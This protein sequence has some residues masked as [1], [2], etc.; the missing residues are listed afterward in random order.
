MIYSPRL[1]WPNGY[2]KQHR[3]KLTVKLMS[4]TGTLLDSTE[5]KF[6]IRHL[7]NLENDHERSWHYNR[8]GAGGCGPC[9]WNS[10]T[11]PE[12][13]RTDGHRNLTCSQAEAAQYPSP[14]RWLFSV[15]GR[16]VFAR[17]GN[18]V[19][20]DLAFGRLVREQARF[21]ALLTMARDL[22]YTYIRI[23]GGG[24]IGINASLP[25]TRFYLTI[26]CY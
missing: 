10:S 9:L 18:W 6:G 23:W 4:D 12:C 15:N 7:E 21:R 1:W 25:S 17:G 16:R 11:Y 19:P 24:L 20:G 3:Y 13:N 5:A 22:G 2:G 14:S 8:Y 26:L